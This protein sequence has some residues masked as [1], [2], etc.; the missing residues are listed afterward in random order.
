MNGTLNVIAREI[1]NHFLIASS[2][3]VNSKLI[4]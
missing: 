1:R 2:W 4:C 3:I